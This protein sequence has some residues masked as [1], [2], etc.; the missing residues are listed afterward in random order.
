MYVALEFLWALEHAQ[1]EEVIRLRVLSGCLS[2]V[3]TIPPGMFFDETLQWLGELNVIA[4][5]A[6]D[7]NL[8][9]DLATYA[10]TRFALVIAQ[11]RFPSVGR[12]RRAV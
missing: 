4:L 7:E 10:F 5:G 8:F 9:H 1:R 11:L 6:I 12:A 2:R 3:Q